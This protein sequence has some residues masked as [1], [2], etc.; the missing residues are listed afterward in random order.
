MYRLFALV[1]IF[2]FM[3]S[4]LSAQEICDNG[5][6]DD[7]DGLVDLNDTTD[8][9]C[10]I[11]S[12]TP[13][14]LPNPSFENFDPNQEGCTSSLPSGLPTDVSQ[15]N[16][17]TGW[18]QPSVGTTDAWNVFT[19]YP[20]TV[21]FIDRVP[22]P[23][24]SGSS[25]LGFYGGALFPQAYD[26]NGIQQRAY[27]EYL[28]ACLNDGMALMPDSIYRLSF[29]LGF[30]NDYS[31]PEGGANQT[32][33]RSPAPLALYGIRDCA[34]LYFEG[35]DCPDRSGATGWELI[36]EFTVNGLALQWSD[37]TLDFTPNQAYQALAL[38]GTC[39]SFAPEGRT[40]DW[41]NYYLI[42]DVRVNFRE[43]F[44]A[45]TGGPVRLNGTSFCDPRLEL[46]G[47][48]IIGAS[49]Q[50]YR[51][52]VAI[53]GATS[54][55]HRPGTGT[56]PGGLYQ[57][58]TSTPEGCSVSDGI[59]I[60]RPYLP[61][62]LIPDSILACL[63]NGAVNVVIADR[64][65]PGAAYRWED[66]STG[67]PRTITL[68]GRY[69]ATITV[70]CLEQEE[71]FDVFPA[72]N[73]DFRV[74]AEYDLPCVSDRLLLTLNT[75]W[76]YDN[77]AV[78]DGNGVLI[79][80]RLDQETPI[81]VN[82][83][84]PAEIVVTGT[85]ND[86]VQTTIRLT[87]PPVLN[88]FE[89]AAA[90]TNLSCE[91]EEGTVELL[92]EDPAGASYNW[93]D[94]AGNPVSNSSLLT[95]IDAG[96][97]TVVISDGDR[98]DFTGTYEIGFDGD[99]KAN[100]ETVPT[101]C[102]TTTDV[103]VSPA[104]GLPPY[105]ILWLTETGIVLSEDPALA[106]LPAGGYRVVVTDATGCK[107]RRGFA[108]TERLA[109][110]VSDIDAR[111]ACPGEGGSL[112][113][114][115]ENGIQPYTFRL[116]GGPEQDIPEFEGLPDG[117]YR[118]TV[119]DS[120][121]CTF[122]SPPV[123]IRTANAFTLQMDDDQFVRLGEDAALGAQV[124]P[125]DLTGVA[126]SWSPGEGLS[127]TDCPSPILATPLTGAV[128]R[129]T[130]T[131]EDGCSLTD[132]IRVFVDATPQFY[133]PTA[134]S[135]NGDGV[136]DDFLVFPGGNVEEI[137]ALRVFDRWGSLV[138][139]FRADTPGWDGK[140]RGQPAANGAYVYSGRLRLF[141]GQEVDFRGEVVLVR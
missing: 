6:D 44:D 92:V 80:S 1:S 129:L 102:A 45:P 131:S 37:V 103:A 96:L 59:L 116:N 86:C 119:T 27:R 30:V 83:P 136:N 84:L 108:V 14:L 21:S 46:I 77:F 105:S 68:P 51:D 122:T 69:A 54:L 90:V 91:Q 132:S 43:V 50:W 29:S 32:T 138:W 41:R 88:T 107:L 73:P 137:L 61:A 130:T 31:N 117:A 79:S 28:A 24:P 20:D 34:D 110:G 124:S 2:L 52:G 3:S 111:S 7:N 76:N 11:P 4:A 48:R 93:T 94:A 123:T 35:A 114:T 109:L 100:L 64:P 9:R 26:E 12:V 60:P 87:P 40:E 101:P 47:T 18:T 39:A 16:C 13:S 49:Y 141:G 15:I 74:R 113:F 98:C 17:L 133:V 63:E 81:V 126:F 67:A 104:G 10:L 55:V 99:F 128:Y 106:N 121:G 112:V 75:A 56:T 70:G 25:F 127:C 134:F 125:V 5:I 71:F 66:G 95:I 57:L 140:V 42:D 78:Y 120:T 89:V 33:S 97:Y 19:Y 38:G 72:G 115:P 22:W 62:S 58:R 65:Y 8:C 53:P 23:I 36:T 139:E 118:I 85:G 135:P 82:P